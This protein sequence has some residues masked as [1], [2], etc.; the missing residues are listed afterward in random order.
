MHE[1]GYF[2]YDLSGYLVI[3]PNGVRLLKAGVRLK[4]KKLEN[5]HQGVRLK[6]VS[7]L[8]EVV[9]DFVHDPDENCQIAM[10]TWTTITFLFLNIFW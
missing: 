9:T 2:V 10:G 4:W 6:Q 8:S 1:I 7:V 5:E 3:F